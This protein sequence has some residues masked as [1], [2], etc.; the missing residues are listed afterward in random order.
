[1][2]IVL[3]S[4]SGISGSLTSVMSFKTS[5]SNSPICPVALSFW[6]IAAAS[7]VLDNTSRSWERFA[8][9]ESKA[10]HLIRLSITRLLMVPISIRR[11]KSVSDVNG[12]P[13]LRSSSRFCKAASP[14]FFTAAKPKRM[15]L[16]STLKF[17]ELAFISGGS[18]AIPI[19]RHC[20]IYTL[21]LTVVPITL[22]SIA[23]MNSSG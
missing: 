7:T 6:D 9:R 8:P 20:S 21:T 14:T 3:R 4:T 2:S 19:R 16:P 1:M 10:P 5:S 22:V 11:Q 23:A 15:A 18:T 12:P 17:T 13:L